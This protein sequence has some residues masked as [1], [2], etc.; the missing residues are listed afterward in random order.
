[1]VELGRVDIFLEVSMVLSHLDFPRE[2]HLQQLFHI[3]A[4]IKRNQNSEMM[5]DPS[6]HVINESLFDRK[7]WTEPKFG[8]SLKED[9]PPNMPQPRG[10]GFVI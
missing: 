4:Y 2:G 6:D 3:F 5:F 8:M 9:M 10:M 1:M 7:Y